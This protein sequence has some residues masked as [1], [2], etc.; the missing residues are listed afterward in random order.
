MSYRI[1][2]WG[3]EV[4]GNL[5]PLI[6]ID[7]F[8]S[9]TGGKWASDE[10]IEAMLDAASAAVRNHCGW[11]VAPNVACRETIDTDAPTKSIW[12]PTT[13]M[14][15]LDAVGVGDCEIEAEWSRIGQ[16]RTGVHIPRGLQA[17]TVEY[18]AGYSYVP[19]DLAA[20][21]AGVIVHAVALSYGV[22]SES[23]GGV[24]VSY[25]SGAAYG[26]A[27]MASLTDADRAA[28]VP[29]VAVMAHAT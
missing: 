15:A 2:P 18:H 21:V 26:G 22:T 5:P 6:D 24:S 25:A 9:I 10:R 14:T 13:C 3:Y 28:L 12:L 11:H 4:N 16:V 17:A 29:Y 1:T 19:A 8:N 23:A 27:A 20:V 7:T